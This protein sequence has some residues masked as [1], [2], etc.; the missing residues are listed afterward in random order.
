MNRS[1]AAIL[2]TGEMSDLVNLLSELTAAEARIQRQLNLAE[3]RKG[4]GSDLAKLKDD[5]LTVEA[6]RDAAVVTLR[7]KAADVPAEPSDTKS[8]TNPIAALRNSLEV[9]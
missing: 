5:L 4:G 3:Q 9:K 6:A 8:F 1:L 7:R 2:A